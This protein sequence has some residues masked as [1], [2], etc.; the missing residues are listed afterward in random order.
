VAPKRIAFVISSWK[1]AKI[2]DGISVEHNLLADNMKRVESL[3]WLKLMRDEI[4]KADT[5]PVDL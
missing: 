3:E 5:G 2:K 1:A 4:C